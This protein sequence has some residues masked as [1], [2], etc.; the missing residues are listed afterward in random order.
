M[1]LFCSTCIRWQS[2]LGFV[3]TAGLKA[4]I[5]HWDQIL[6]PLVHIVIWTQLPSDSSVNRLL[7]WS[8]PHAQKKIWCHTHPLLTFGLVESFQWSKR[9]ITRD[10]T[11]PTKVTLQNISFVLDLGPQ[12]KV[13]WVLCEKYQICALKAIFGSHMGQNELNHFCPQGEHIQSWNKV[14]TALV[15]DYVF[16]WNCLNHP[17]SSSK[18]QIDFCKVLVYFLKVNRSTC[19]SSSDTSIAFKTVNGNYQCMQ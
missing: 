18:A 13:T 1:F 19:H 3:H 12:M 5:F 9:Q 16:V 6:L 2:H 7:P 10:M 4:L 17:S 8:D 15:R 14:G 11:A